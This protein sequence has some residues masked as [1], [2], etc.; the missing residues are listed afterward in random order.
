RIIYPAM[1]RGS[2]SN[3]YI[4]ED[5]TWGGENGRWNRE[6][7][8]RRVTIRGDGDGLEAAANL[9]VTIPEGRR[10]LIYLGFGRI[11]ASTVNGEL[12]LDT[13]GG[14]VTA[15]G[16]EGVLNIDT[17][18]GDISVTDVAG[19]I[20]L[21]TGSGDVTVTGLKDGELEVDTG[22]GSVTGSR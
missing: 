14:D 11:E 9:R 8:R 10:V 6:G 20:S 16:T 15:S 13:M 18:S 21:D 3:F 1:G 19:R 7:G 12:H 22:S 17:G 2:N 4:R 5:G